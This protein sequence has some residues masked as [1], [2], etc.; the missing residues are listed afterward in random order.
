M[1]L[2]FPPACCHSYLIYCFDHFR[3]AQLYLEGSLELRGVLTPTL[4]LVQSP[5]ALYSVIG[6][7]LGV[8]SGGFS[9]NI[10]FSCCVAPVFSIRTVMRFLE[11]AVEPQ[12]PPILLEASVSVLC[13]TTASKNTACFPSACPYPSWDLLIRLIWV[14]GILCLSCFAKLTSFYF[15]I[16]HLLLLRAASGRHRS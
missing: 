12:Q 14:L 6:S 9:R 8:R 5:E 10:M 3:S 2:S 16:N 13:T 7:W 11:N 15:K 4:L 1:N